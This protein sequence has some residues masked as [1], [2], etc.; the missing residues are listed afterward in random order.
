L[1]KLRDWRFFLDLH[2]DLQYKY[3]KDPDR[4]VAELEILVSR[5][6]IHVL[7]EKYVTLC[8]TGLGYKSIAI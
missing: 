4:A 8:S 6:V 7:T 2:T 5:Y 1:K 3:S